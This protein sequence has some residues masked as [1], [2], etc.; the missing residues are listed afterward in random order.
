MS[1]QNLIMALENLEEVARKDQP[2]TEVHS[3]QVPQ[4]SLSRTD[5]DEGV[6]QLHLLWRPPQCHLYYWPA[7]TG[8]QAS[9]KFH[10]AVLLAPKGRAMKL[11]PGQSYFLQSL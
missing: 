11:I 1:S 6:L 9:Q 2:R 5:P 10:C 8:S 3:P 7:D 4:I